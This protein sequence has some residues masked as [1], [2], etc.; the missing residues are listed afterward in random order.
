VWNV[1]AQ[2]ADEIIAR[3]RQVVNQWPKIAESV[4]VS[5]REQRRM[6]AAFRLAG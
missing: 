4:G 2:T 6:A 1:L 5:S 3:S